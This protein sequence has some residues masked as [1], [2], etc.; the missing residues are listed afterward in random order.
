MVGCVEKCL[1]V[2]LDFLQNEPMVDSELN[3]SEV[4]KLMELV[5]K[6]ILLIILDFFEISSMNLLL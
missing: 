4:H 2:I 1:F 6:L 3:V 5:D